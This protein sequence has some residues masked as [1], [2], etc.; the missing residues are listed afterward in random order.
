MKKTLFIFVLMTIGFTNA[1][2]IKSSKGEKYL[3][4]NNDWAIGF[5]A[6]GIFR[7]VG[8]SLNGNTNNAAP[9]VTFNKGN[10]GT[11]IGKKFLADQRALRVI[12]NLEAGSNTVTQATKVVGPVVALNLTNTSR[13]NIES[14]TSG[15]GLTAGL[16]KEWRKGK[17]RLQGFYGADLLVT[18]NSFSTKKVDNT[19]ITQ[20]NSNIPVTT[21]VNITNIETVEKAGFV[22]GVG[23]QGFL[24]AEYFLFPKIAIGAQYTYG[25][26]LLFGSRANTAVTTSITGAPTTSTSVDGA[27]SSN[28][29]LT[30]VGIS[31]INLT[32][33][34]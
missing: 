13:Q 21:T 17:T 4:E 18:L 28:I 5:N 31:S 9:S 10:F 19:E 14:T 11:F 32:L 7:Y 23:A 1:Q 29:G 33:H 34:F 30:G 3:P 2:D 12:V 20:V 15:F 25:V 22:F 24:G 16:G 8:N 26:N 27:G 6:D